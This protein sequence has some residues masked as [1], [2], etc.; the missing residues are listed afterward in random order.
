M[1][2][3]SIGH[4]RHGAGRKYDVPRQG[5]LNA[6]N[7]GVVELL[8]GR[9]FEQGLRDLDGFERIW[10][11]F[12]F[13]R[14]QSWRPTVAPPVPPRDGRRVGV[15]ASRS[16]Y[17]PNPIGLTCVRLL[18]VE[19]LRLVVDEADLLDGTPILDIKPYIPR[20]DAFPEARAG[21]VD[22]Q[23]PEVWT[24]AES[25]RFHVQA[26][27]IAAWQGPDLAATA[28]LQLRENPFDGSR[29]RVVVDGDAGVL[30][31]RMF[32]IHFRI[33]SVARV[34]ELEAVASGYSPE[35]LA[36]GSNDPHGDKT[37]HARFVHSDLS[38]LS[39][40]G[41]GDGGAAEPACHDFRNTV[42]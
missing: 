36:D 34:I 7:P 14:N 33:D 29:K 25:E 11:L 42:E 5:F 38:P 15:F 16:P 10:L 22:E 37:L 20:A 3:E 23:A 4:Y 13:D 1:Q 32:R 17:R 21:W 18:A 2:F 35:E 9:G 39:G 12:Q 28:T 26:A 41:D 24:V 6:G 19:G 40:D 31:I 27:W 30:A 8:G